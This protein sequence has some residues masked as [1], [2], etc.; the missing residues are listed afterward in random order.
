MFNSDSEVFKLRLCDYTVSFEQ[1][2]TQASRPGKKKDY[3]IVVP[4]KASP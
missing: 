2:R 1:P 3:L 4:P